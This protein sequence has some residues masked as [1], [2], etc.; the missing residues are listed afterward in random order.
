MRR[1]FS[2]LAAAPALAVMLLTGC[3]GGKPAAVTQAAGAPRFPVTAMAVK[4]GT[5]PIF[6]E[7]IGATFAQ[8][9]VQV[10]SRVNGYIDK[11]LFKPGDFVSAGQLLYV[12]DQRT[13]K[14][15]V[16]RARAELARA[17]AQLTFAKEGVE[18]IRGESELAQ[19]E[20]SLIKAE[21]DVARVRPLVKE[22]ALP[23]QDLD[24]VLA[25][26]RVARNNYKARDANV[27][28]L[29][30]SQKTQ[31]QQAQAAVQ[32]AKAALDTAE[33]NL[34]FTEIRSPVVGRAGET[35]VQVGGLAAANSPEPLTL[36]SP[37]DPIYVE[38][39]VNERD[40]LEYIRRDV[41]AQK[42]TGQRVPTKPLQLLL[43]DGS[44]YPHPGRFRY[45]DRAVDVQ[46]GTLKL[47]GDFPNPD[48]ILLPG[49][50]GRVRFE[51]GTKE[52]VYLVPQRAIVELQGL[53]Q[54][55]LAD[56]NDK[57]VQR[58]VTA[59][60]RVGNLWVIEKG[61]ADG[62]RVIVDGLQKAMPGAQ[63]TV[64]MTPAATLEKR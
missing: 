23:E 38:F 17:E 5:V 64:N 16:D 54:V 40:Y 43:A 3:G 33:L 6:Q 26:E 56:S 1:E 9:T 30:F 12:I 37:L 25:N 22:N 49:Q 19:A 53:R 62:D 2:W 51:T 61:L 45:A 8:D 27:N 18:V 36:V 24:A 50:F 59:T 7:F 46:T 32:A 58:T 60:D 28:Q 55:L 41:A 29:R 21:Q 15:E 34:S 52:G 44:V 39:Q 48:R 4:A 57:V 20:A 13:Y 10:N 35:K 31:I 47:I 11:W 14:A 42:A 63:V